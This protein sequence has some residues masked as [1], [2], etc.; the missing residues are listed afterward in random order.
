MT[1]IANPITGP[2]FNGFRAAG[3]GWAALKAAAGP[4]VPMALL[5]GYRGSGPGCTPSRAADSESDSPLR[6]GSGL[7]AASASAGI[8]SRREP[9][10]GGLMARQ[11][12]G[13]WAVQSTPGTFPLYTICIQYKSQANVK[14]TEGK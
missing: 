11:C 7:G 4:E 5:R 13:T 6:L 14:I 3:P 10:R 2:A 8:R 1:M 9:G 12:P